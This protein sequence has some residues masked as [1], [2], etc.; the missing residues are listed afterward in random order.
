MLVRPLA[1]WLAGAGAVSSSTLRGRPF[2]QVAIPDTSPRPPDTDPSDDEHSRRDCSYPCP[3]FNLPMPMLTLVA[4]LGTKT[5]TALAPATLHHHAHPRTAC[6]LTQA[7]VHG[8]WRQVLVAYA[9]F[10][11]RDPTTPA[12]THSCACHAYTNPTPAPACFSSGRKSSPLHRSCSC[13]ANLL[14]SQSVNE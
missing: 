12:H 4:L 3:W 5:P 13:Q 10:A 14:P 8:A 9:I 2:G 11:I 7:P 1:D 6:R